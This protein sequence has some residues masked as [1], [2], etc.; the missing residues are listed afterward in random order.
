MM[1]MDRRTFIGTLGAASLAIRHL[2]AA[3]IQKVGVQ[4]YTVRDLMKQD[5]DGTL[6]KIAALGYKEVEFAGYFERTPA[7][8]RDALKKN[9]LTAPSTHVDYISLR[10]KLPAVLETAKT[11]GHEYVVNP[12]LDESLRKEPDIWKKVADTLNKAGDAAHKADIQIAYHN[13]HFEFA[14]VDGKLPLDFLLETCDPKLVKI[15]MDLCWTTVAGKDPVAYFKR[16]PGRFPLV[17]VKGLK[18]APEAGPTA[19]IPAVLPDITEVGSGGDTI[20]WKRIFTHSKEAGIKHYFV[21]HDVPKMP[22]ESL[23]ASYDYV[24]QLSF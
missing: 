4:L 13:H 7:Q 5:F 16:F 11:V 14:P 1:H 10:D 22:L 2:S 12:W 6:A 19:A 20:D 15:E 8:V 9:G 17:H 3:S 23:K 21:E 18:K 24:K